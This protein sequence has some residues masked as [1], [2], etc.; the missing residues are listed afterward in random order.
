MGS[1]INILTGFSYG[2][3]SVL[4]PLVGIGVAAV[5]AYKLCEPLG[6]PYTAAIPYAS[7][8]FTV[9]GIA[10]ASLGHA[11]NRGADGL[12]RCVWAQSWTTLREWLSRQGLAMK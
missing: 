9:F 6:L 1:A 10:I 2:L 12:E 7:F 11:L 4:L 8:S 5:V 3:Y